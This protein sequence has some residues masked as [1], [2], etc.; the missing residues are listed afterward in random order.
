MDGLQTVATI[1]DRQKAQVH[2]SSLMASQYTGTFNKSRDFVMELVRK[3]NIACRSTTRTA[4][5]S[6]E[7]FRATGRCPGAAQVCL[8]SF[9]LN[10]EYE[11][12][13]GYRPAGTGQE[14]RNVDS[15]RDRPA[16]NRCDQLM[17]LVGDGKHK[18]KDQFVIDATAMCPP[19]PGRTC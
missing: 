1:M 2:R 15:V 19:V 7:A 8:R 11:L 3:V 13:M 10:H 9:T 6:L 16:S 14:T 12:T 5:G 18:S 17:R 4:T